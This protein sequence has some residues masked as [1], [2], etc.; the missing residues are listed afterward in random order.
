VEVG[1]RTLEHAT[2][3][4]QNSLPFKSLCNPVIDAA[5]IEATVFIRDHGPATEEPLPAVT[6][7][8]SYGCKAYTRNG[9]VVV[10]YSETGYDCANVQSWHLP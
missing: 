7:L 5:V 2:V 3:G 9:E 8:F 1:T 4:C 6:D 10:T